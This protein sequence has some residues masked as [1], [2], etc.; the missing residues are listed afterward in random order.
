MF[1][2]P[3]QY[4]IRTGHG[5]STDADGNNGC[6][7]LHSIRTG[8]TLLAIASD[9][10]GWE[11]VSV[12]MP[13]RTPTWGEMCW[14]RSLFWDPAACVMQLHPPAANYRNLHEHCLHLWRP[15]GIEIPQ[16]PPILVA[17]ACA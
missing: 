13:D 11:H 5:A 15:I 3:N 14:V 9:G 6:F 4:R 17:P 7:R 12:S 16:P 1:H 10:A 8:R 2:V